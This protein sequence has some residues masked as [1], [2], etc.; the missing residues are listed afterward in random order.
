MWGGSQREN[1]VFWLCYIT[2]QACQLSLPSAEVV[3]YSAFSHSGLDQMVKSHWGIFWN[4]DCFI[5][6]GLFFML[7]LYTFIGEICS[8]G[9]SIKVYELAR[10]MDCKCLKVKEICS[11]SISCVE[12]EW[13][14]V[15][16]WCYAYEL[17]HAHAILTDTDVHAQST[18]KSV[19]IQT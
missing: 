12:V 8:H 4:S 5:L 2:V 1:V 19:W 13:R 3:N 16:L 18:I 15:S 11:V 7:S 17:A 9:V 6:I 14:Q 10:W